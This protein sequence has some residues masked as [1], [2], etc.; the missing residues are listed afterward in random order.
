MARVVVL[1]AGAMGLAAAYRALTLGHSV[2]LLEAAPEPGGMAAH[3]DLGGLSIER[4]YHFVC[5]SDEPTFAL[6]RELGIGDRMRWRPTS[7]GYFIDGA[8]H[9][10]GDP[11]A[12]LRFPHLGLIEK[13]RY[14]ALM[15]VSTRRELLGSAGAHVGARMDR[16][17]VRQGGLRPALAAA[18]RPQILRVRRQRL[19][20]LDMDAH[21]ARR[22]LAPLAPPGGARLHRGRVRDLGPCARARDRGAGRR[23]PP[24]RAGGADPHGGRARRGRGNGRRRLPSGRRRDLDRP[25]AASGPAHPRPAGGGARGLPP[26]RQHRRGLRRAEAPA[27]GDAAFLGQRRGP[28]HAGARHHR[29][30]QPPRH[31]H[32][33]NRRLRPLLHADDQSALD[34]FATQTSSRKAS[35]ASA[36]STQAS[37]RATFSPRMSGVCGTRS[38]SAP[39]ASGP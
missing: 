32:G 11:L 15:F 9:R 20:V 8:L 23:D 30:L 14:G 19:R 24:P 17:L 13:L 35:P 7:M 3:F 21:P 5:K 25:D 31:R 29:V 2:T 12:L 22:P 28:G 10:W 4:F 16:A 6:M 38:P 18:L 37:G 27:F 39:R 33:R 36:A 26:H 34:A 1:G